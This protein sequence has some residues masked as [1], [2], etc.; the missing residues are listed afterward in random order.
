MSVTSLPRITAQ[1]LAARGQVTL[2]P[3]TTLIVGQIGASGTA[4]SG[5]FYE[6]VQDLT[7]AE[8]VALFGSDELTGR[9]LR[10]RANNNGLFP[11]WV[12]GLTEDGA[13]TDATLTITVVGT[14]TEDKTIVLK[15]VD[16]ELYTESIDILTGDDADDIAGKIKAAI[17]GFTRFPATSGA[18]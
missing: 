9:I 12:V 3:W 2:D 8:V 10:A 13:A 6:D 7:I 18:V 4:V 5:Q 15:A 17:D 1:L 16:E 14:A 11:I